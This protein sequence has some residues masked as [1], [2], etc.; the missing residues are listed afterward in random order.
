ME[1]RNPAGSLAALAAGLT[2]MVIGVANFRGAA[3]GAIPRGATELPAGS[4]ALGATLVLVG[5]GLVVF[6]W[7]LARGDGAEQDTAVASAED[8][9]VNPDGSA[10]VAAPTGLLARVTAFFTVDGDRLDARARGAVDSPERYGV[11]SYGAMAIGAATVTAFVARDLMY[12]GDVR[13]AG[14]Q[15]LLQLF[16]YQY[17]RLW[18]TESF[19]YHPIMVGFGVVTMVVA[20]SLAVHRW[21]AHAVRAMVALAAVWAAWALD[22]YMVDVSRHWSQRTLFERYFR[23][24]QPRADEPRSGEDA[25]YTHDICGAYMMNWKG[26][27]FY[28]GGRC[29][30]LDCGDLPF[31]SNHARQWMDHHRGQ[32]IFFVT[33]RSHG[34][35]IMSHV[36]A[37]GGTARELT[38]AWDQNKFVLVEATVGSGTGAR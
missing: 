1:S 32:R 14:Y 21:R 33:E 17:E 18:P 12:R 35:S 34:S 38:D 36:R 24:R 26:E 10:Q 8:L 2:S 5:V 30:M 11:I 15:R 23:M 25:R 37:T 22:I 27:N 6:S 13:P 29:A 3:R 31:C 20:S 9:S 4:P 7:W 28:T 19:D 16:T